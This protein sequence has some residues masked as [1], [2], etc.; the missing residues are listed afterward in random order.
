MLGYLN[1]ASSFDAQGYFDTGDMVEV[2]G[3]WLRILG[4]ES[5]V[6]NV[7]GSKV[8]PAEVE[9]VLLTLNNVEDAA[10]YA[11]PNSLTGQTVAATIKLQHEE[12]APQFKIRMRR[13]C[14]DRLAPYQIPTR[15]RFTSEPLH[16]E[17]FKRM[18]RAASQAS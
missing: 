3:E 15:V 16:S 17:R 4:R 7:G 11:E 2:D 5:E 1:A 10:V 12:S 9:S 8:F 14:K 13:F 18:R 6:I